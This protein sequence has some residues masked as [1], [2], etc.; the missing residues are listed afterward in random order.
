MASKS[1]SRVTNKKPTPRRAKAHDRR[2][3]AKAEA[4]T[5]EAPAPK[6]RTDIELVALPTIEYDSI[7]EQL[8]EA[9]HIA[10]DAWI[11]RDEMA[12]GLERILER[13]HCIRDNLEFAKR[14][15]LA[16]RAVEA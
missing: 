5:N 16:D 14:D 2:L 12:D 3:L 8:K 6:W 4:E 11:T 1:R 9:V 7:A 15:A 10:I 13:I